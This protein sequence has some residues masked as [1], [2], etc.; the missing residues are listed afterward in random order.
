V[1]R[2][3]PART[4]QG[5]RAQLYHSENMLH[6]SL[7]QA[8]DTL[9]S[10]QQQSLALQAQL[11]QQ[12]ARDGRRL[13]R[14]LRRMRDGEGARRDAGLVMAGDQGI[15]LHT[16]QPPGAAGGADLRAPAAHPHGHGAHGQSCNDCASTLKPGAC[17]CR[18]RE[19]HTSPST[20]G[21]QVWRSARKELDGLLNVGTASEEEGGQCVVTQPAFSSLV[22][23]LPFAP[24]CK[25][26]RPADE[27]ASTPKI[28][29]GAARLLPAAQPVIV[30]LASPFSPK[31]AC[32]L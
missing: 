28:A 5:Q 25:L 3:V 10:S 27:L 24:G 13:R 23:C 1:G 12:Q 8:L 32:E 22:L 18:H 26:V 15:T 30:K 11:A 7:A 21:K 17:R 16:H 4:P 14:E 9:S 2:V 31:A 19:Q 6:D 20:D 29:N